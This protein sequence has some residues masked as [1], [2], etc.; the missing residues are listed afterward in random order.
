[1]KRLI[2]TCLLA[3]FAGAAAFATT[4]NDGRTL[5]KLWNKYNQAVKADKPQEEAAILSQIKAEALEK[6]LPVDFYDAATLYVNTVL[7]RDWKQRETLNAQ[8]AQE[9]E[10]FNEPIVTFHWMADWKSVSKDKLLVFIK[11]H[12]DGFQGRTPAFYSGV[13]NILGGTLKQFIV[14]DK[15]YVLWRLLPLTEQLSEEIKGRY[16]N[17]AALEYYLLERKYFPQEQL[18]LKR[19][20]YQELAAKYEGKAVSVYSKSALLQMRKNELDGQ[21]NPKAQDYKD[22]YNQAKALQKE[23][24]AYKGDEAKVAAGCKSPDSLVKALTDKDLT[25]E[26]DGSK[27]SVVFQNLN[28]AILTLR[29]GD[30]TV[31]SWDVENPTGSFYVEDTVTVNLPLLAD[32]EYTAEA[33]NGKYSDQA[34]YTQYT[35]S[36]ATRI[37]GRGRCVYVADYKTGVPL[38]SV[39][40]HLM[41][42]G[43]EVAQTTM[44]LDGFTPLP[45]AFDQHLDPKNSGFYN[46]VAESGTR[47]S[48]EVYVDR[49]FSTDNYPD[50]LRCNFYRDRGAYNPGDTVKFKA[51]V[52]SGDPSKALKVEKGR[53]LEIRL[54]DSQDNI[55][56]T[57]ELTTND[58]GAVSGEFVLPTGLR[59]GRFELEAVGLGYDWFRVDEFVL[60]SFD[61]AFDNTDQLYLVG[62]DIPVSG[63]VTSYSGHNLSGAQVS[64]KVEHYGSVIIEEEKQLEDNRFS[65]VFPAQQSGYYDAQ[66]TVTDATGETLSFSKGFYV[67]DF[68]NIDAQ[69][70][71]AA[72]VDMPSAGYTI[73]N[74]TLKI[75]LRARDGNG[76]IVPAQIRYKVLKADDSV[77]ESGLTPSGQILTVQLPGSGFYRVM[78]ELSAQR[79]DGKELKAD[80]TFRIFSIGPDDRKIVKELDRIFIPGPLEVADK[81]AITARI[82]TTEG[83]AYA[84]ATLYGKQREVLVHKTFRVANES[85]DK[86]SFPY[87]D[88]YPDAVALQ[89]FYFINGRTVC[90]DRVYRRA[91]DRYSMPLQFTRFQDK[92]YPGTN[93]TFSLKTAKDAEVLV[94]AWDKSMDAIAT[95]DWTVVNMRDFFVETAYISSACGKVGGSE[96]GPIVLRSNTMAKSAG[97]QVEM[98]ADAATVEEAVPFQMVE[99][100]PSFGGLSNVK[101][102]ENFSSALTFQ[103]HLR[104]QADGTLN[105]SFSTADKL[106]T[107][108]VR[109]YAHDPSMHNALVEQEMIVSL[110]VKV[111]LLEPRYLYAGDVYDAVVTVS[112]ITDERVSGV[113][114]L[115]VGEDV[116]QQVPVV[117]EPGKSV[118]QSFRVTAPEGLYSSVQLTAVF[119]A[120]EFSD[121]VRVTVPVYPAAQALIE[122]HSAV[123]RDGESREALLAELRSRF[124]N[125]PASSASLKEIT[126]LD[127]VRDAIPTHVEPSGNDVLSLSEAW[128]VGLLAER[129][130]DLEGKTL[131]SANNKADATERVSPSDDMLEKIMACC[132]ADGGFAWFEGMSSSVVITAVMLERFAKLRDRGFEVPDVYDSVQYLDSRQFGDPVPYW[133]GGISDA[134]YVYIRSMYP[135]VPFEVKAVSETQ[136]KRFKEFKKW[137]KNYL[138][139]SKKDGRGLQGRILEKARRLL[140]LRYL[141]D[142]EDGL[143]LA[144]AW[145]VSIGRKAK[146]E[147]SMKADLASLMEY[148]VPHRDGGWYYP[149]A[150]MPWRGLMESEAY[151]HA[152][153]CDLLDASAA[154]APSASKKKAD[155]PS[156][157]QI[158]DGIRLWLMLQKE[159]QKWDSSAEFVDAITSILDGSEAVLNTSVLVLSGTYMARFSKVKASGNGF[160]VERKFYKDDAE[161]LPGDPVKVGDKILVKYLIWNGENRSF[162]KLTAGREAS[163]KPVQQLSGRIGYGFIRPFGRSGISWG[164]VPQGYRNVK[165][166]CTEFYF[167][168]YP[169]EKTELSEEFY[170]QQTGVFQAPVTVIESLYAPHYRANSPYRQALT[171]EP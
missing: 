25:V 34:S 165:A 98:M 119:K 124:V 158:A 123:L 136:K 122:A 142:S 102:R 150:V 107:Y 36:I 81:G 7:R 94:A 39:T 80:K 6:H 42:S 78:A 129:L 147:K 87:K 85:L 166:S 71:D 137:A 101:V 114:A 115:M 77:L 90:Y 28:S 146:L 88:S 73:L 18:D 113:V 30:K 51:I 27:I 12:E 82:G 15:E 52:Y 62:D 138:T 21:K 63:L 86:L 32:G 11:E 53:K 41:K 110:P 5:D 10:Q 128:Y 35:L 33:V 65:F 9:I 161:I 69:V 92:A 133:C 162:V 97:A 148:A 153:L 83:D 106:S 45:K 170:V 23:R 72:D 46:L 160:T 163:L 54:H 84:V 24:D 13:G 121:A 132:N 159:T 104:P 109:A 164:F 117:V 48:R 61:L 76:N 60:P 135:E 140:T 16:P 105:F 8:L 95:N 149:N 126:V 64:V 152:L 154:N 2:L 141:L 74:T 91:K 171:V 116:V 134:V 144:K 59:N 56:K 157:A 68:L 3:V 70:K 55:I 151:A 22:L 125:I 66:V 17:E 130:L 38:R 139:P 40:L 43:K 120:A 131:S 167:D 143:E 108:Y 67:S 31:Y 26:I 57:L 58:W 155:S 103:P 19:K 47:R 1:M 100:K 112:S 20:A 156:A 168:S 99:E 29:E 79:K 49:Y 118:T 50:Q 37:D 93:Y 169:E 14:N 96:Y 127:M 111:A 44:K 4:M 75:E 89:V 145:G